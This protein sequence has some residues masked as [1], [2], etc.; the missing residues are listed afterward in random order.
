[1]PED[2]RAVKRSLRVRHPEM[3]NREL[4]ARAARITN[5]MR[6]KQGRPPAQFHRGDGRE[7]RG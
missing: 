1:V 5:A 2:Y 3:E 4:K 7:E 6:K